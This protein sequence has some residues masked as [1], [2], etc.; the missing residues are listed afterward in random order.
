MIRKEQSIMG[1]AYEQIPQ[2]TFGKRSYEGLVKGIYMHFRHRSPSIMQL[3]MLHHPHGPLPAGASFELAN[4][5][6][7]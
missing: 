4:Q 6:V 1:I 2:I 3:A 5:H 7:D